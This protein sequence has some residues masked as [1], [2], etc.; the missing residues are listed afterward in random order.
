M[1]VLAGDVGG[2]TTRLRLIDFDTPEPRGRVA[3]EQHFA[4]GR[5]PALTTLVGEFLD[6]QPGEPIT[7]ACLAL[8]GPIEEKEGGQR[9]QLTNLPWHETSE[10]LAD[11]L[12]IPQLRLINDFEAAAFGIET[13][14]PDELLALQPATPRARAPRLLVG[15]GTG[16]GVALLTWQQGR[17]QPLPSEAGHMDFAPASELQWR[18][19]NVL[20]QHHGHVSWERLVSGP[21]LQTLYRFLL[22][23]AGRKG[24]AESPAA[25]TQRAING[26]DGVAA[27][28]LELFLEL[29]GAFTGNLALATLP[30]GGVFIAGGIAPKIKES[31]ARSNFIT[32]FRAKGRHSGLLA[33]LPVQ[34]VMQ[35]DL[36]LRGAAVVARR[37]HYEP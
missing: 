14:E 21:G 37:L 7:A 10:E 13:L 12:A 23:E 8:A 32:A 33:A 17:Y 26:S 16:L 31:M 11:R 1:R 6:A 3:A 18:L 20:Q 22:N 34:L 30:R 4:S 5:Y 25:I 27:Q 19:W 24:G 28:T 9:V 2:T 36:G 15:A 29:Y 35:D